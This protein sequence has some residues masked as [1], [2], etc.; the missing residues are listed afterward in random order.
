VGE[1][2]EEGRS[3]RP[4]RRPVELTGYGLLPDGATIPVTLVDLSYE[5]CKIRSDA[6]LL[7]GDR[8]KLSVFNR[9]LIEAE[10]R[11]SEDGHAGLA[12]GTYEVPTRPEWPRRSERVPL[13]ASVSLRRPGQPGFKVRLFDASPEGCR[14]ER[15]GRP[16]EGDKIWVK[17]DGLE[18]LAAE[19]CWVAGA[20][21]GVNFVK[22][23]H[24]AVFD[25]MVERLKQGS[26]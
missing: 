8:L 7:P 15:I 20:E 5:G 13:T 14:I 12:F 22:A 17:F 25:L 26:G 4:E 19:V 21:M 10:V 18:T 3:A 16:V 11:W 6:A 9:G 24:P 1:S 2:Q 23:M